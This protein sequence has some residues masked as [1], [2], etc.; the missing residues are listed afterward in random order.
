MPKPFITFARTRYIAKEKVIKILRKIAEEVASAHPEVVDIILF[1]SLAR[2]DCSPRSDAD[3][4]IILSSTKH[5][6]MMDRIP[7]FLEYFRKS[8]VPVDIIPYTKSELKHQLIN[9]NKFLQGVIIEGISLLSKKRGA[10]KKVE[11]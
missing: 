4:L 3:I 8:L 1:G 11:T 5:K 10:G 7:K 9:K 2:G 6:R